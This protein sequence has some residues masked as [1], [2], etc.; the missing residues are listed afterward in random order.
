MLALLQT[1]QL[2]HSLQLPGSPQ[3]FYYC[4]PRL[5]LLP[6]VYTLEYACCAGAVHQTRTLPGSAKDKHL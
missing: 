3:T 2:G 5:M 1:K 4:W 6:R